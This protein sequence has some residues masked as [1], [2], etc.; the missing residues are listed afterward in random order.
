MQS[1]HHYYVSTEAIFPINHEQQMHAHITIFLLRKNAESKKINKNKL[2][3]MNRSIRETVTSHEPDR[4]GERE[5]ERRCLRKKT[6]RHASNCL[7]RKWQEPKF[8]KKN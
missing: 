2:I 7:D 6:T 4:D 8:S 1:K 5:R 3:H